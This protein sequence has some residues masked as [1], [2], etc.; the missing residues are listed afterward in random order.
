MKKTCNGEWWG[1]YSSNI[2]PKFLKDQGRKHPEWVILIKA[3]L[4]TFV[5]VECVKDRGFMRR[6][7]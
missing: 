3:T 1:G 2:S 6:V 7:K 5:N 4:T